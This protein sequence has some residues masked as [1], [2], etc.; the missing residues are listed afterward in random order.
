MILVHGLKS[1]MFF[2]SGFAKNA[3]KN[4]EAILAARTRTQYG[5]RNFFAYVC[6]GKRVSEFDEAARSTHLGPT[7]SIES[8][9]KFSTQERSGLMKTY[10]L[11]VLLA[12][13]CIGCNKTSSTSSSSAEMSTADLV[14]HCEASLKCY[15]EW[16]RVSKYDVFS[17]ELLKTD[18]LKY[19]AECVVKRKAGGT[20]ST[21]LSS[22]TRLGWTGSRWEFIEGTT[23]ESK[24]GSGKADETKHDP[25]AQ[26][27]TK[28][29]ECFNR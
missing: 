21:N 15:E 10:F 13:V 7:S 28:I 1:L 2:V 24:S 18:N 23:T 14:A 8:K 19:Q 27:P 12:F 6:P 25:D 20:G 16:S 4:P 17:F 5:F 29:V 9:L 3:P 26:G 22:M 11:I